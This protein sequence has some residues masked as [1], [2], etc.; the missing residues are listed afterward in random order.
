VQASNRRRLWPADSS[1]GRARSSSSRVSATTQGPPVWQR[2]R[3][4]PY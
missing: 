3:P 1:A 2:A 4:S